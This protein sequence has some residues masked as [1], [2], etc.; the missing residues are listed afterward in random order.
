MSSLSFQGLTVVVTGAGG[1]LGKAYSLAYASRGANVVVNDFNAAAAQKVVDE[2]RQAGGKAVVNNSSVTDGAAVIKTALDNFGAV[3]ILINNAGIL[4]DKNFRNMSDKEWDQIYEVHLKGAFSCTKAAW[5]LFRKQKFGRIVNTASAAGLYGNFGQA[6]YSAAK[7]GLVGFTKTLAREGEKYN[8]RATAIAP[9]AASAMTET[10]M[11]P[12]MLANIKPEFVAPF[13]MAVTHPDSPLDASGKVFELGAGFVAEI[14]WERSKGT[15]FKTDQ[16]FTPSAVKA[17]W[18]EVTDFTDAE[19]PAT[20][21]DFDAQGTLE[22]AMKLPPNPQSQPEVR[23]DGKTVLITGAGQGLGRAY[24]LM[25]SRLGANV[26]VNDVSEKG[27]NAVVDEITKAGGKAAAAVGS[28]EDGEALV[29]VA[30]EK[31]GG[32]HVLVANAGILRDKSFTAMTEQEWDQVMA[33]HLRGTYKCVKACWPHFHKQKY[34]RIVNTSSQVG[35]YGNFGQA[36]YSAAKA[37]IIGFT[38]ALAI[39]GAKYN[40]K[41][42]AIAP[43]AGTAMTQTIWPPEMVEAFKPDYIA[44][45]VGYLTSEA[46]EETSG[47]LFEIMGGWAAQTRWQ[48]AGGHG[49]PTNK[50]LTP[51]AILS[52]WDVITNFDDG[53][54]THP[55]STQDA[56]EQMAQN[57]GHEEEGAEGSASPYADPED[58]ELV[59]KAKQHAEP[60][61]PFNYTERDVILYNLGIGA[62]EKELQWTFENDDEFAALPTFGVIPQFQCQFS[63]PLDW[64]PDFNPAKLLHGEQYLAIKAPIPTS[65]EL[66]NE[67][68]IMEVL[69]K[70]KAASV[71]VITETKDKATGQVIFE[72]QSTLFIRGSGG[73]GGKRTGKD[74]GPATA[75]NTPPK[76]SPDAVVEEKTL[77]VQAALYRLSGDWNPLHIQPEFAAVGGFDRPIL[78]GLCT[79]GFAGKH[80]LKSFGPY[81]D[82]KARFAGV[83]FPG[84]TLVTEMWKEGDK[85]IFTTK[86]KERDAPVLAAAA[87]TLA[88]GA[89]KAKL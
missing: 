5:P 9:M 46:N 81:K 74:R 85:V 42:N 71:A 73:F 78:H 76:R 72:N 65:G 38:R 19:H 47:C 3:H 34:G 39:E 89:P 35:I 25:Y 48:K 69:D 13:V 67:A 17:K 15:V 8:I 80:V 18:A 41:A 29:K 55:T 60:P 40:I 63:F 1:G 43:S 75:A 4:R 32:I 50:P 26:V 56:F 54:A 28:V 37:A 66:V 70:G 45:I 36:N 7:M 64:L 62:T 51:E 22:K 12:E 16:T 57:F 27:A 86:V 10:I 68:R 58:P 44:P 84:E 88:D 52:K 14:R 77:P 61:L 33:V 11:P 87:V 30:L 23:Y 59:A 24:A 53:R 21:T 79:F 20:F 2:I 82:I 83:V 49:F 31:F 6:N